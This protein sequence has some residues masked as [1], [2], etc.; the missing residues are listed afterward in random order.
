MAISGEQQKGQNILQRATNALRF[1]RDLEQIADYHVGNV[2]SEQAVMVLPGAAVVGDI[3]AERV[4]V[5]GLVYGFIA[6]SEVIVKEGGQVWGDVFTAAFQLEVGGKVH[7]W[8]STSD[9]SIPE[10]S[11]SGNGLNGLDEAPLSP[12]IEAL[13]AEFPSLDLESAVPKER[14]VIWRQLQAEAAVAL[15]ARLELEKSFGE[16]VDEVAG[17]SLSESSRLRDEVLVFREERTA[18]IEQVDE[19]EEELAVERGNVESKTAELT[20]VRKL[21]DDQNAALEELQAVFEQQSLKYATF[22]DERRDLKTN[23]EQE[24]ERIAEMDER[25]ANLESALQGSFQHTAEQEEALIRWQEL[26]EVTE[27][28]ANTLESELETAQLQLKESTQVLEMVRAQREKLEAEWEKADEALKEVSGERDSIQAE[29]S[30]KAEQLNRLEQERSGLNASLTALQERYDAQPP[31]F[32]QMLEKLEAAT[33]NQAEMT[34]R[35]RQVESEAQNYHEQ[36]LWTKA[37]LDTSYSELE[38]M[39][40]SVNEH[41]MIVQQLQDQIVEKEK[42]VETWKNSMGRM[43][44]LL[45]EAEHKVKTLEQ[46][47]VEAKVQ[48][49]ESAEKNALQD[50]IRKQQ[51]QL[52]AYEA[53]VG[54][55]H[56]EIEGQSQRFA[57][58]Q[59]TLIERE[60]ALGQAQ[61]IAKKQAAQLDRVKR[62]AGKRIRELEEELTDTQQKLNDLSVW[63]ERRQKREGNNE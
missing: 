55:I 20:T 3:Q 6:A 23:L 13:A 43:T 59:A 42:T 9:E 47:A 39:R 46:N 50:E 63:L 40:Q 12:E 44:D 37:S 34:E 54:H 4:V 21:L 49:V 22:E 41:E 2:Q 8:I 11:P 62:M 30:K 29:L 36:W 10:G 1:G 19:L 26:A 17:Q 58:V 51:L 35:L 18:L 7:G 32:E 24:K 5:S 33:A 31:E 38:A 45:Y 48:A 56:G 15:M 14:A 28:R 25:M 53:E 61:E 16:R 52:E 60:I 27:K 57:E